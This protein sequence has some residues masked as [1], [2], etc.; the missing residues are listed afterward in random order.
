MKDVLKESKEGPW[1]IGEIV[2]ILLGDLSF[3]ISVFLEWIK[4]LYCIYVV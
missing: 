1:I 2:F 4:S 3:D